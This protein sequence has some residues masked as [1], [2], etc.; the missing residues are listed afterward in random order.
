[1]RDGTATRK[2]LER[3]ALD[4]FVKKGVI[5]TTIKD[6]ASAADVAEGTMYRHYQS[7]E[8]LATELY[9]RAYKELFH[10]LK[11]SIGRQDQLKDKLT[12]I[13]DLVCHA[14]D[15]D[16]ITFN[17]LLLA[18]HHQLPK[19]NNESYSLNGFLCSIFEDAITKGEIAQDDPNYYSG[20]VLGIL[21]QAAAQRTYHRIEKPLGEDYQKLAH[22]LFKALEIA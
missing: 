14:Y 15:E 10:T 1:M 11:E 9:V 3:C 2:K 13:C 19:I 7:K 5:A 6:I 20:I 8:D 17:Y 22:T 21:V 18:Q 16:P 4:L 12:A